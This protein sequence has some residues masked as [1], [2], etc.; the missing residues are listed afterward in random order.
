MLIAGGPLGSVAVAS[1]AAFIWHRVR[2]IV[3]N[4]ASLVVGTIT[5]HHRTPCCRVYPSE[6]VTRQYGTPRQEK[7]E[8]PPLDASIPDVSPLGHFLRPDTFPP[9][10]EDLKHFPQPA[11]R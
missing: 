10:F 7:T 9:V 11:T 2:R 8:I 5:A 4:I 1:A 6:Q 3:S